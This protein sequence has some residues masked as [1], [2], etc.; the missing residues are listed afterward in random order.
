[1]TVGGFYRIAAQLGFQHQRAFTR[2]R[3]EMAILAISLFHTTETLTENEKWFRDSV[4]S[5]ENIF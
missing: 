1:M 4:V 2:T 5:I 3:P